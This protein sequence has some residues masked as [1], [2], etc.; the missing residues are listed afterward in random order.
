MFSK[1][2]GMIEPIEQKILYGLASEINL[3]PSDSVVEFGSFFG[4]STACLT[5]G[6]TN[7]ASR[8]ITNKVFAF[9]SFGCSTVGGFASHVKAFAKSG[10]CAHLLIGDEERLNFFPVFEYYLNSHLSKDNLRVIKAE[11]QNSVP[12]DISQIALMHIDSPKYY[13]EL[14]IIIK[15]FFNLL[16]VDSIVVFQDYFYHW[17]ATLIAAVEA[18]RQMQI[19]Q[20]ELSAASSLVTKITRKIDY[21]VLQKLDQQL[22]DP[23]KV[24]VL[25][26]DAV[27]ACKSIQIDRVDVFVPR[28]WLARYQYLWEH[29][30]TSEATDLVINFLDIEGKLNQAVLADYFE[31]MR[32]GFS[33]RAL[34]KIDH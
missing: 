10:G 8:K 34:Y 17:S 1:I 19:L 12:G 23:L 16:R 9:D 20:Y 6:L 22:A 5:E 13:E 31:M 24:N 32:H 29:N 11:L 26:S 28:I 2:P 4:R 7:N 33:I 30:K 3:N 18:M 25:L 14:R 27:E 15:R 21:S